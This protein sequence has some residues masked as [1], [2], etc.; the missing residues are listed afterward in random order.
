[1]DP[2]TF[3]LVHG[4][5]HGAWCWER[6]IPEIERHGHR[7]IAIDLPIEDATATFDTYADV[8]GSAVPASHDVV[9]VAHSLGAMVIPIVAARR[10]VRAMVFV[11]GVI[12]LIGGRPWDEGPPMEA[13]GVTSLLV[14]SDDGALSW[15]DVEAARSAMY[16]TCD[17]ADA[18]WCFSKLRPQNSSSLWGEYP[19]ATWPDASTI[20]IGCTEDRIV[21]ADWSRYTAERLGVELAEI[22]GDHSPFLGRAGELAGVVLER[23]GGVLAG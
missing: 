18:A 13:P 2:L 1:V 12:P 4:A 14:R 10:P 20:M 15:P 5:W 11:S 3:V 23:V 16:H 8:V 21:T 19:L 7:A 6:F 9:L 22:G 17:P